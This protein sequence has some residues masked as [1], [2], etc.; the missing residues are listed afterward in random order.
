MRKAVVLTVAGVLLIIF[1][2]PTITLPRIVLQ[3]DLQPW[4][5]S[6]AVPV[7]VWSLDSPYKFSQFHPSEM[8]PVLEYA[9]LASVVLIC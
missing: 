3:P 2:L 1:A 5:V 7:V 8:H 6:S 9:Q 4:I